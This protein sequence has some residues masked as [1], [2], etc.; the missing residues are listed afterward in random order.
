MKMCLLPWFGAALSGAAGS[1]QDVATN[2]NKPE[3]EVCDAG[4]GWTG[5]RTGWL[6]Y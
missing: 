1:L 2:L 3:W 5:R 6:A 4:A